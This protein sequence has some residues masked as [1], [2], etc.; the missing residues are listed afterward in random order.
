[1]PSADFCTVV[2]PPYDVILDTGEVERFAE[3]FYTGPLDPSDRIKL[4]GL[5]RQAMNRFAQEDD[6]GRQEEF[7]QL[8]KSYMRFYSFV[9]QVVRLDDTGRPSAQPTG[10]SGGRTARP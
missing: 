4:E 2:R 1:M 8:L 9:A 3:I 6:E 5:V 10:R 7:R